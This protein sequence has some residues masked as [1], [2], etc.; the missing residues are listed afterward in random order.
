MKLAVQRGLGA[1]GEDGDVL[2]DPVGP[3]FLRG[4]EVQSIRRKNRRTL[5]QASWRCAQGFSRYCSEASASLH[6]SRP[7]KLISCN[8]GRTSIAAMRRIARQA[9][10]GMTGPKPKAA[11]TEIER[12]AP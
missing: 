5:D 2:C 9:S 4:I 11:W 1:V 3:H 7:P 10:S 8:C 12:G 6:L